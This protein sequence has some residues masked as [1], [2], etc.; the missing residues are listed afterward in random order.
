M[1][2]AD[3]QDLTRFRHA[4]AVADESFEKPIERILLAGNPVGRDR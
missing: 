4:R 3:R 1:E 2:R